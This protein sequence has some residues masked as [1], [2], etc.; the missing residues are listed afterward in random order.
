MEMNSALAMILVLNAHLMSAQSGPDL[1]DDFKKS[2]EPVA[3]VP[4]IRFVSSASSGLIRTA[5]TRKVS[6]RWLVSESWCVNC[7]A[8]KAR[9]IASGNDSS[10]VIT[11][12][13]A[14]RRHGRIVASVPH[15]YMIEA[16]EEVTHLQPATYRSE[17]PPVWNFE[18]DKM[19]SKEKALRHLR[20][21]SEHKNKHLQAWYLESWP[22]EKLAA[23]HSDD[24]NGTVPTFSESVAEA[25]IENAPA[26]AD[27]IVAALAL[28]LI[29]QSE[30]QPA[31]G[32]LFNVDVAAPQSML[33]VA[34][35]LL[36]QQSWSSEAAGVSMSWAGADRT[37]GIGSRGITLNPG[38]SV[39]LQRGPLKVGTTLR[40]V[41][42]DDSLAWVTLDLVN[43]PDLTIRFK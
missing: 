14:K 24:H 6:Q 35:K 38:V 17:W 31:F 32:S 26:S 19:P 13:E 15:E 5:G 1:P 39:T 4:S 28:H 11:I 9:F 30:P 27:T 12:A 36:I 3:A 40:A 37:I 20:H 21:G 33:D 16:T 25:V 2:G 43:A 10:R 8:A 23:L 18:G 7:P 34:R 29:P 41:S 22:V 42:Y